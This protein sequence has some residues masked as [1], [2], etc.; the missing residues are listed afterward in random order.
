[1]EFSIWQGGSTNIWKIPYV[2]CILLFEDFPKQINKFDHIYSV[3]T[4]SR[5]IRCRIWSFKVSS[6]WWAFS[7]R[8]F[9]E[10]VQSKYFKIILNITS[11]HFILSPTTFS[12]ISRSI[13]LFSL[14]SAFI[15]ALS[16]SFSII[17]SFLA[18]S[19]YFRSASAARYL[20]SWK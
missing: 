5:N 13:I 3:F 1:M 2:F 4:F 15:K 20:A 17:F 10:K 19:S 9:T 11:M 7:S 6:L 14:E 12:S 16:R 8:T 18:T